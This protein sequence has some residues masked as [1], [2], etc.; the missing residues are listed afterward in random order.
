MAAARERAAAAEAE[1]AKTSGLSSDHVP[2]LPVVPMDYKAR[3][4]E[5]LQEAQEARE[6]LEAEQAAA[7]AARELEE[8]VRKATMKSGCL[9][10]FDEWHVLQLARGVA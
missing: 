5:E 7:A 3:T 6:K 9:I 8:A 4:S 2:L 10:S 1:F